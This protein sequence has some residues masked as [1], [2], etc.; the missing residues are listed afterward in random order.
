MITTCWSVKGG[1][2]TTVV[3]AGLAVLAAKRTTSVLVIDLGLDIGSVLGVAAPLTGH[4]PNT[5]TG[6][7]LADWLAADPS[8]GPEALARLT[9][10]SDG[11]SHQA[12]SI[13]ASGRCALPA[14][15]ETHLD[16]RLDQALAW[17]DT[18]F[19][20]VFIDAGTANSPLARRCV[21]VAHRSL[22]VIRPCYLSLR[23][24]IESTLPA[25]SAIVV[26]TDGRT[27][28]AHDVASVLGVPV[29]AQVPFDPEIARLVDSG[30]F[31]QRV[32]RSVE[33]LRK[34]AA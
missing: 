2:G 25:H 19:D 12:V 10:N 5:E 22:L 23:L 27:L 24:A 7:G 9:M 8:V 31:G 15:F 13:L 3:A 30:L 29:D 21:V 18:Q 33:R 4:T 34:V 20:D 17:A 28:D 26:S 14:T 16:Q 11:P 6:L 32:P 1:S